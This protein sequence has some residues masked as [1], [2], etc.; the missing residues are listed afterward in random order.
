M[1]VRLLYASRTTAP[2]TPELIDSILSSSRRHNPPVG[3]TGLLCHS[4]DI[5]MQVLEG[6]RQAISDLYTRIAQAPRHTGLVLLHY[7]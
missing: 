3:I 6:G 1:L 5:F 7:E 4:G 2:L